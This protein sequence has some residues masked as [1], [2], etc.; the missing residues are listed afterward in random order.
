MFLNNGY[1]DKI[2]HANIRKFINKMFEPKPVI[3]TAPKEIVYVTLPFLSDRISKFVKT[4]LKEINN[5]YFPQTNI[6]IAFVNNFKLRNYTNHK[7]KLSSLWCSD[8][9]YEY[10]CAVCENCYIGSTNRSLAIKISEHQGRS[11][12]TKQILARPLQS[13]IREHSEG[14][15]KKQITTEEFK[16]KYKGQ[17]TQEIRIAESLLI[18]SLKPSLN[19]EESSI[20]LKVF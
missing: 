12:R 11:Y 2:I 8:V 10:K 9:V 13:S 20:Q 19:L 18:K 6:R 7:D 17:Y 4:K 5:K 15:C 14:I 16:V 3:L 1:P